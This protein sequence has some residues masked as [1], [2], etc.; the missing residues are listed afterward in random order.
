MLV[1]RLLGNGRHVL[2]QR[3]RVGHHGLPKFA[4]NSEVL[5]DLDFLCRLLH[6]LFKGSRVLPQL[7]CKLVQV[8]ARG[9]LEPVDGS[10]EELHPGLPVGWR[11]LTSALLENENLGGRYGKMPQRIDEA[12]MS[13]AA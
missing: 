13:G 1:R 5:G 7:V 8:K 4:G 11:L 2:H 6:I 3:V 10:G 9:R 12:W